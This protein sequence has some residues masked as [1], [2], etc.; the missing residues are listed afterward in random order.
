MVY[1]SGCKD[2]CGCD[3]T[4][5]YEYVAYGYRDC[6]PA[7]ICPDR[8]YRNVEYGL[9]QTLD[10][11][12]IVFHRVKIVGYAITEVADPITAPTSRSPG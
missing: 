9:A 7:D 8:S 12:V 3:G 6:H 5:S 2:Y 4:Y 10:T 11:V 1:G